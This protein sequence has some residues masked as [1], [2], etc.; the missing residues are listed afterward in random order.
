MPGMRDDR[1]ADLA[2]GRSFLES[3]P[4][5]VIPAALPGPAA[6]AITSKP[7]TP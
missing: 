3:G 5:F 7:E 1:C 6:I 4:N 2:A